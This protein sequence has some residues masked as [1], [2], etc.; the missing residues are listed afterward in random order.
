M[1][2]TSGCSRN[3]NF[4]TQMMAIYGEKNGDMQTWGLRYGQTAAPDMANIVVFFIR[5]FLLL[6][7]CITVFPNW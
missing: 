1:K 2:I 7:R 4:S 3:G 6:V 5:D